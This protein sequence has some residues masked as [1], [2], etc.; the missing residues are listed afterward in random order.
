MRKT[1]QENFWER[2]FGNNYTLRNL[3]SIFIKKC[4][5]SKNNSLDSKIIFENRIK[6]KEYGGNC[7]I[8][9]KIIYSPFI[10]I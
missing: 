3:K 1:S 10:M 4:Q 7:F 9:D 2:E 5:N 6:G 8:K